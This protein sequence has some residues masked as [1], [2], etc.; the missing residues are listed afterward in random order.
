MFVV[1]AIMA[2]AVG[3]DK[4]RRFIRAAAAGMALWLTGAGAGLI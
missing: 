3:E 4:A 2:E 1:G